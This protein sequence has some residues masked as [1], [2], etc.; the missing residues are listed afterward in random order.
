M[1][2]KSGSA[3]RFD[4]EEQADFR[5]V[6]AT[7]VQSTAMVH[8]GRFRGIYTDYV[9]PIHL[10]PLRERREDIEALAYFCRRQHQVPARRDR[11]LEVLRARARLATSPAENTI[12]RLVIVTA[13]G[14]YNLI[15]SR[16]RP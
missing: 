10:P 12:Y 7:N 15:I 16:I 13:E 1:Y 3:G 9:F 8:D 5:V 2:K 11:V 6:A 4:K 14:S